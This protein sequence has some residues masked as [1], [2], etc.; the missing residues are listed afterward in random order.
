MADI[1]LAMAAAVLAVVSLGIAVYNRG[2]S[3]G[4]EEGWEIGHAE[5]YRE[6]ADE[7]LDWMAKE[8]REGG[9]TEAE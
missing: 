8:A 7:I 9:E 1:V 5:G 2:E 3:R 4:F 6:A